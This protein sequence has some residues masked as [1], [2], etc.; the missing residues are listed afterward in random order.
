MKQVKSANRLRLHRETLRSLTTDELNHVQAASG[1][2]LCVRPPVVLP[3]V[4][5]PIPGP[6]AGPVNT[7]RVTGCMIGGCTVPPP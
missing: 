2:I 3:P 6:G 1:L 4:N 5:Q 7:I